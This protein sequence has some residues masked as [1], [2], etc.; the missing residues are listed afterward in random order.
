MAN[1]H[2]PY[3]LPWQRARVA[4]PRRPFALASAFALGVCALGSPAAAQPGDANAVAGDPGVPLD[5]DAGGPLVAPRPTSTLPPELV[6]PASDEAARA[7]SLSAVRRFADAALAFEA[8]W[9]Q[10]RDPRFLYHAAIAWANAGRH[11]LAALH[12]RNV[13]LTM[14]LSD[15]V[16]E[17]LMQRFAAEKA[18]AVTVTL[19]LHPGPE[20][21]TRELPSDLISRT[22]V[23]IETIDP[24]LA[25][26][27]F[28]LTI[29]PQQLHEIYLDPG[30]YDVLVEVHGYRPQR[31][32]WVLKAAAEP[33][34]A[35]DLFLEPER[36][37]VDLRIKPEKA[38][39]GRKQRRSLKLTQSGVSEPMVVERDDI[40]P[41]ETVVLTPG[42]W[43]FRI[44]T[45]RYYTD[46]NV[47]ITPQTRNLD[48]YLNKRS[49]DAPRFDRRRKA[50][51]SA[52]I[53]MSA[54]Y[55]TGIGL[56]LGG[57]ARENRIEEG[58]TEALVDL[59]V[60]L[61]SEEPLDDATVA[62]A[63]ELVPTAEYHKD[64]RVAANLQ[65]AGVV[66][67]FAGIGALIG[68]IPAFTGSKRRFGYINLGVSAA[69]LGGGIAWMTAYAAK[70]DALLSPTDPAERVTDEEFSAL[71]G[72]RLG[73][74]FLLGV[75]GGLFVETTLVFL[76]DRRRRRRYGYGA[77]PLLG[78]GLA[79]ASFQGRF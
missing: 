63:E 15:P 28:R 6:L 49:A 17:Q 62:A 26:S 43:N 79:G 53:F 35:W 13:L 32:R 25:G 24:G 39:R 18:R 45:P 40:D 51:L 75:G 66:T 21:T 59:G 19:R 14:S 48:V 2:E 76:I 68:S 7:Q 46:Y 5:P 38:F 72:H 55:I 60:D 74:G 9:N 54:S 30:T 65:T 44:D 56:I 34:A 77:A 58:Y 22:K 1:E 36:V 61:E 23:V 33:T 57:T 73:A 47:Q 37:V 27:P 8:L 78:P 50:L 20:G 31:H 16:R 64:L 3:R 12:L 67:A 52:G 71:V 29:D 70:S 42:A 10:T 11:G 69:M 4:R 41:S